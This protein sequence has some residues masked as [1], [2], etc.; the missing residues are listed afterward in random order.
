MIILEFRFQAPFQKASGLLKNHRIPCVSEAA[1][2]G[3]RPSFIFLF[4]EAVRTAT[5]REALRQARSLEKEDQAQRNIHQVLNLA[6][7][8]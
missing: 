7:P 8:Q 5:Q 6:V 4:E 2:E 3:W 1:M